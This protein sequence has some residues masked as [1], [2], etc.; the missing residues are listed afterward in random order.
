VWRI[1]VNILGNWPN[2]YTF[3]KAITEDM[4]SKNVN[5]LPISIF[6]PSIV[7]CSKSEPEPG[8]MQQIPS[9]AALVFTQIIIGLLRVLS[10]DQCKSKNIVPVDYTINAM[11]SVMWE[12]VYNHRDC[13]ST[14]VPKIYNYVSCADPPVSWN[15]VL[16]HVREAYYESPPLSSYWY[17]FYIASPNPWTIKVSRFFL[18]RLPAAVTDFV[19][20]ILSGQSPN[21]WNMYSKMDNRLDVLCPFLTRQWK[22]RN[23]NILNLWSSLSQEDRDQFWFSFEDFDWKAYIKIIVHGIKKYVFHEDENDLKKALAKNRRLFWLHYSCVGVLIYL[24][25][26]LLFSLFVL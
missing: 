1:N 9:S 19:S 3:T 25:S 10:V 14:K 26:K 6:R 8:W 22:F 7:E 5:N 11:I 20:V 18:H 17:I 2:T 12:T 23:D 21:I 16:K 24:L 13:R 4:I 15:M